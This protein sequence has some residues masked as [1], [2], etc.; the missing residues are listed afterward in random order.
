ML[1]GIVAISRGKIFGTRLKAQG[2]F[3]EKRENG[4]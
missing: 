3:M 4:N 2:K 1:A